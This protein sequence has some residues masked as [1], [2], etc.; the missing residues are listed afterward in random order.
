MRSQ[1]SS[2]S[3]YGRMT[4]RQADW[5]RKVDEVV[6]EFWVGAGNAELDDE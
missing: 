1:P 4:K 3:R 2:G 5:L 6:K